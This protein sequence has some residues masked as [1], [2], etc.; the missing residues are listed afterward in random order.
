VLNRIL[1][2]LV[3]MSCFSASAKEEAPEYIFLDSAG[4]V[5]GI[6]CPGCIADGLFA[7]TRHEGFLPPL[8]YKQKVSTNYEH[9]AKELK[10]AI[11][12]NLTVPSTVKQPIPMPFKAG[13]DRNLQGTLSAYY[14]TNSD[15]ENIITCV[16]MIR[17]KN[18]IHAV[19]AQ[20]PANV[21]SKCKSALVDLARSG[22]LPKVK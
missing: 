11:L 7:K 19:Y 2:I 15:K 14:W 22:E 12:Q 3:L 13:K 8:Q 4:G 16:A 18:V 20:A 6:M 21:F 17:E 9:D 1:S 5:M 10:S